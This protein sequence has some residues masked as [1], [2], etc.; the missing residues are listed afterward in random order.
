VPVFSGWENEIFSGKSVRNE[1]KTDWLASERRR[2]LAI[3]K[4]SLASQYPERE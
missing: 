2:K 1:L 3:G 4:R